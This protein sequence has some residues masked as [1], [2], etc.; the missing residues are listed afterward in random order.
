MPTANVTEHAHEIIA[1]TLAGLEAGELIYTGAFTASAKQVARARALVHDHLADHPACDTAML[2]VSELATNTIRHSDS[3]FFALTITRTT[4]NGVRITVVD[5]G[6][7]G[8]PHLHT[9]TVDGEHGR[10][11]TIVDLLSTR[12]GIT[13]RPGIGTAVWSECASE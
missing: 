10:G 13:R 1:A 11:M 6:Q 12:W 8:I 9:T 4:A 7:A 2:L 3:R 5:E